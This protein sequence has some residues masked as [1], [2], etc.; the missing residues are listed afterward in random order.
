MRGSDTPNLSMRVR[1]VSSAWRT[2]LS[3]IAD[4]SA[5]R[6]RSVSA[7]PLPST[8]YCW[9]WSRT[10]VRASS[11]RAASIP[12]RVSESREALSREAAVMPFSL[13]ALRTRSRARSI[14]A[15]TASS[16]RTRITMWMPPRRSRP[17][18]MV[19]DSG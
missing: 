9:N 3:R 13:R 17:R 18:L 16:V 5:G 8:L 1:M 12:E 19:F 6:S 10:I 4:S 11:R 2:A 7:A 14:S 15:L